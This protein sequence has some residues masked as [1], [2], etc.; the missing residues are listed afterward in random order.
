[1]RHERE[2]EVVEV[3]PLRIRASISRQPRE[4]KLHLIPGGVDV[5]KDLK[6]GE[7]VIVHIDA[8]PQIVKIVRPRQVVPIRPTAPSASSNRKRTDRTPRQKVRGPI[9]STTPSAEPTGFLNP[10]AMIPAPARD[11]HHPYLGD[12][13]GPGHDVVCSDHWSGTIPIT[14]T[15]ESPLLILD[16]GKVEKGK[17][18]PV[19]LI[20]GK[21]VL[22]WTSVKGVLRSV[23][24]AVTNSRFAVFD[25]K[26]RLPVAM[27]QPA[28]TALELYPARVLSLPSDEKPGIVKVLYKFAPHE[29]P[30]LPKGT[31]PDCITD[32]KRRASL[33]PLT[34]MRPDVWVPAY[35]AESDLTS[36]FKHGADVEAWVQLVVH[37]AKPGKKQRAFWHW[38]VTDLVAKGRELPPSATT[39]RRDTPSIKGTHVYAK[40][41]G[42]L[43]KGGKSFGRK[44][45]E[46]L[47]VTEVLSH[48]TAVALCINELTFDRFVSNRW[49][50]VYDSFDQET[51]TSGR[52]VRNRAQERTLAPDQLCFARLDRLQNPPA[53][54]T[55]LFPVM[56]GREAFP[57]TPQE[58]LGDDHRPAV[59]ESELSPADRLFGW[60]R[61][62]HRSKGETR[63]VDAYRG[64][65]RGS[66]VAG[67]TDAVQEFDQEHGLWLSTLSAPKAQQY[68]FRLHD[69]DGKPL[70][71]GIKRSVT[72]GYDTKNRRLGR[73]AYWPHRGVPEYYWDASSAKLATSDEPAK[74]TGYV[75]SEIGGRYREYLAPPGTKKAV[76]RRIKS[77]VK[78][79]TIFRTELRLE[80]VEKASLGV[81][82]WLLTLDDFSFS[83]GGGKPLG[84]GTVT[85]HTDLPECRLMAGNERR[86]TYAEWQP[87]DSYAGEAALKELAATG[88]DAL[89]KDCVNGI[90]AIGKG[91]PK[92]AVHYPRLRDPLSRKAPP[93]TT[94]YEWFVENEKNQ[95]K[96]LPAPT[97]QDP[98]LPYYDRSK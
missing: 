28:L 56:I 72:E 88:Y 85:I 18:I 47:F 5:P 43:I 41:R 96:A 48:N 81:L 91:R 62:D 98:T 54:V 4:P 77:W 7:R 35:C 33:S 2:G 55:D 42:L 22:E 20:G 69:A 6:H 86:L 76:A 38:R 92:F 57:A 97:D 95:R 49:T 44:H 12:A 70:K 65:V 10:Y 52:H 60:A 93:A 32:E 82:L 19:R 83:L 39:T 64:H 58:V 50:A 14:I 34:P 26:Y 59:T 46:R 31:I 9:D 63:S 79:G 21:P 27:R 67:E 61:T 66:R 87:S 68:L 74:K 73:T 90:L 8:H 11:T 94:S 13:R 1:M 40:V 24:E 45:D 30:P 36:G 3:A 37:V 78:P 17:P 29:Y 75:P 71:S 16:Q 53:A 23:F 51:T 15:A 84:F 25:D 89:S 80:N